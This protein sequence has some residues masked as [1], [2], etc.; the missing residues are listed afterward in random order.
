MLICVYGEDGYR[1]SQKV[2]QLKDS[3]REKFSG[4]VNLSEFDAKA[5]VGEILSAIRSGGLLSPKRM[6]VVS[7]LIE[8]VKT[9]EGKVWA[10]AL[11]ET[12]TDAIIVLHEMLSAK[13]VEG[14][15]LGKA[16]KDARDRHDYAFEKLSSRDLER[17]IVH[18]FGELGAKIDRK[19]LQNL[20]ASVGDNTWQMAGE[21]RKLAAYAGSETITSAMVEMLVHGNF[22]GK[23]F[24]F[25]DAVSQKNTR[26]AVRLLERERAA[27]SADGYLGQ[28]LLRQVRLLLGARSLLDQNPSIQK[29]DV[30]KE[31]GI[32]PFVAQK[33]VT[34]ARNF[35]LEDL[36][37]AHDL[38]FDFDQKTKQGVDP[39]LAVERVMVEMLK[40]WDLPSL[41]DG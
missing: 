17:W 13:E 36:I 9:A 19:A 11:C 16:L 4:G 34:Q 15:P 5:P 30:A 12:D 39:G 23:I 6:V 20:I 41:A 1:A 3:F 29:A 33:S 8:R 18:E 35:K 22:E 7:G 24:D 2:A 26:K 40:S 32:H 25:I 37:R 10:A 38:L 27:G 31:L 14:Q 21:M 28:M